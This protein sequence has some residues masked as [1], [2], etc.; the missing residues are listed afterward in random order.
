M[1]EVKK[2]DLVVIGAGPGGYVAAIRAAQLGMKVACVEKEKTLGGTCLNIGCIPSKALLESSE[3]YAQTAKELTDHGIDVQGLSLDL[4]R[5]M[6][7]KDQI[8]KRLTGGVALLFKK[9]KIETL[10][11]TARIQKDRTVMVGNDK[12][13]APHIILATGSVPAALPGFPVD[14]ESIVDST[15]ALSLQRIPKKMIVIGGGY[16]GLEMGSV[17]SRL[18]SEVVVLEALDRIVPTMDLELGQAFQKILEKQGIQFRLSAKVKKGEIRAPSVEVT[19]ETHGKE[20]KIV[21][22]VILVA[23]GRRPCTEGLGLKEAEIQMNPKGFI[24]VNEKLETTLPGVY[25]V[26]DCIRGPMLAHKASEEGIAVVE[27]I[28]GQAGHVNYHAIPSVVYTWPEVASVGITEE[29]AKMQGID[30][31]AFKFPFF[32]NG[33]AL[34]MGFREGFVKLIADKQTDRLLGAH[35]I[36][37]RASD[38]IAEMV[39]AIEFSASAEDIARTCHAHPTLAEA[40]KEA[41]LGLGSG[42][43]HI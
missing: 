11:G 35:I 10:S 36:G 5:F 6:D 27:R 29:E 9:N 40:I 22:D 20:E 37:P 2:F 8:V 31:K 32:A 12:L 7:R 16:I 43:I 25:A 21:G 28:A 23:V 14:N 15:G 13:S 39:L 19:F 30:Y 17:Y 24:E 41:A 26:G 1:A 42:P 33:R 38:M 4:K 3:K 18:G 34:S